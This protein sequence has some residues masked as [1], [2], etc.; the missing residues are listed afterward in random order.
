MPFP[1]IQASELISFETTG[2]F[3]RDAC[4]TIAV[5][6]RMQ[7][8]RDALLDLGN[9]DR[10]SPFF[11]PDGF[12]SPKTMPPSS[13]VFDDDTIRANCEPRSR[14]CPPRSC[15]AGCT[16]Q[17]DVPPWRHER[18]LS[19]RFRRMH[20]KDSS[21]VSAFLVRLAS[22]SPPMFPV[23]QHVVGRFSLP[24]GIWQ[25]LLP[26]VLSRRRERRSFSRHFWEVPRAIC[27]RAQKESSV[28]RHDRC[29]P[30][31]Q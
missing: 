3:A 28:W 2:S 22:E 17:C 15:H 27:R 9:G 16:L 20:W 26:K 31:A 11:S 30:V 23:D 29:T 21:R 19:S 24:P 13:K 14:P 25:C 5:G 4:G 8:P 1:V 10:R 12:P 6:C 7:Q 18:I